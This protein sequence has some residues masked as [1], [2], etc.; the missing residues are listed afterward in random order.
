MKASGNRFEEEMARTFVELRV[1]QLAINLA[2][3]EDDEW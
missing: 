3:S 1:I 2:I